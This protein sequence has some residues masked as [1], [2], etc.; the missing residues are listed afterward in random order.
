[1]DLVLQR[2]LYLGGGST[3]IDISSVPQTSE[4]N[5]TAQGTMAAY[6]TALAKDHGWSHSFDE[7]GYVIGLVNVRAEITYQQGIERHW[8]RSD[9]YDFYHPTLAGLGEQAVLN[10]EIYAGESTD[11]DT[12]GYIGRFDELRYKQSR[13][14]GVFRSKN[15]ASLDAWHLSE[16]FTSLPTLSAT[17]IQDASPVSRVV[18]VSS[19]PRVILDTWFEYRCA[20]PMPVFGI[21]GQMDRF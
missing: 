13:I 5:T 14:T 6:G 7:H 17:F 10:K 15:S 9:R 16:E 18:A 8:S 1:M 4:T 12:F 19:E 20:R 2:P 3:P 21:P 11:E